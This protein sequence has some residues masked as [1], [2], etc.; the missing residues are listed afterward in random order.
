MTRPDTWPFDKYLRDGETIIWRQRQGR[1]SWADIFMLSIHL[2]TLAIFGGI[3]LEIV[4]QAAVDLY[5][6]DWGWFV[7]VVYGLLLCFWVLA[8]AKY[9]LGIPRL[10]FMHYAL[11]NQR[12]LIANTFLFR[13]VRSLPPRWFHEDLI[14]YSH[15]KN[16]SDV[17][18]P[19]LHFPQFAREYTTHFTREFK[20][21]R[22]LYNSPIKE[23][24]H[25]H[26][27]YWGDVRLRGIR[28]PDHVVNLI[29]ATL[30][31]LQQADQKA[32]EDAHP[33][34]G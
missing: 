4:R 2:I 32:W 33:D 6:W 18:V 8:C 1:V 34:Y 22:M 15:H 28:D 29:K 10:F 13:T 17:V 3:G 7:L 5:L 14:F 19:C 21:G 11:T 25:C 12:L 16:P 9:L 24:L 20:N 30:S 23:H 31:P 27:C 26:A